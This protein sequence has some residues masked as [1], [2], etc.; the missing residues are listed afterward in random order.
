MHAQQTRQ[1]RQEVAHS[2][3]L[4][5]ATNLPC[6]TQ[7]PFGQCRL[8]TQAMLNFKANGTPVPHCQRAPSP[9]LQPPWLPTLQTVTRLPLASYSTGRGQHLAST[10]PVQGGVDCKDGTVQRGGQVF[11]EKAQVSG[12]GTTWSTPIGSRAIKAGCSSLAS[13]AGAARGG[14]QLIRS[15][16]S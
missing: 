13:A 1:T 7:P 2:L 16:G 9:L 14:Q 11:G 8:Q 5:P 3:V 10:S 4:L 15:N 12:C 6:T